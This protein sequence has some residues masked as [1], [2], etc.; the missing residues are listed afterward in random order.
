[1]MTPIWQISLETSAEAALPLSDVL[2]PFVE[3]ISV[4]EL[5]EDRTWVL[6]GVSTVEPDPIPMIPGAEVCPSLARDG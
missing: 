3:A 1:M 6:K 4:F 2:E 5:E